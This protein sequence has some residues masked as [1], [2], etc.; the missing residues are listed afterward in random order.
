MR[1]PSYTNCDFWLCPNLK[2]SLKWQAFVDNEVFGKT[3]SKKAP[4]ITASQEEYFEGDSGH[5]YT[6]AV[7]LVNVD[8]VFFFLF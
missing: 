7:F 8:K 6:M 2:K 3:S 4:S 5:K 1:S